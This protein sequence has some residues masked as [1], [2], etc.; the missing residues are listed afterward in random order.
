MENMHLNDSLRK[1]HRRAQ[2]SE[3]AILR[4]EHLKHSHE[5]HIESIKHEY[6]IKVDFYKMLYQQAVKQIIDAGVD[7]TIDGDPLKRTG[8]LD[9]LIRRLIAKYPP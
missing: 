9:E 3:G 6:S 2:A 8:H 1:M 4:F 7:D 5:R